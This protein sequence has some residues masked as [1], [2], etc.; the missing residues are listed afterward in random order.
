MEHK[1][2]SAVIFDMD[3]VLVDSERVV[4]ESFRYAGERTGIPNVERMAIIGL[5]LNDEAWI[6]RFRQEFGA[7]SDRILEHEEAYLQNFYANGAAPAKKGAQ[8]LLEQLCA[9]NIP[10]AVAS[11]SPA[12]VVRG[13]LERA[14]LLQYF[15]VVISGDMVCRSKPEPDIFL[16][17]ARQ[18]GRPAAECTVIEDSPNGLRAGRRAGCRTLF[19]PDL[20]QPEEEHPELYDA[21]FAD[22]DAV[23]EFFCCGALSSAGCGGRNLQQ[24][25]VFCH[26]AARDVDALRLQPLGKHLIGQ[27]SV[28][29]LLLHKHGDGLLCH[30]AGD[31]TACQLCGKQAAQHADTLWRLDILPA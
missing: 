9:W 25:A 23:R 31:L 30:D 14:G 2:I 21:R 20:W 4:W 18:L 17:A 1:K 28:L 5:G 29:I 27:G 16:E 22:L 19:V 11:S 10:V 7:D 3:G 24:L 13:R 26:G 15:T 8:R 12:A 6:K